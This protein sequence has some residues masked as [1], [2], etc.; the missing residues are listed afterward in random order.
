VLRLYGN[1]SLTIE[2]DR[3]RAVLTAAFAGKGRNSATCLLG[4]CSCSM[5]YLRVGFFGVKLI[6]AKVNATQL[7]RPISAGS[8]VAARRVTHYHARPFCT[9][10]AGTARGFCENLTTN[11]RSHPDG[12][13]GLSLVRQLERKKE[14]RAYPSDLE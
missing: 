8:I 2:V 12:L 4:R 9:V 6:G 13:R 3:K 14:M 5:A 7:I 11:F 10:K 1:S